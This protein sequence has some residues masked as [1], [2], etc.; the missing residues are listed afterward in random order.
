M[1]GEDSRDLAIG[2]DDDDIATPAVAGATPSNRYI[3]FCEGCNLPATGLR[4]DNTVAYTVVDGD[5]RCVV[6]CTQ[7]HGLESV[8]TW[9]L[10]AGDAEMETV[11]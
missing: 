3:V 9:G 6:D 11:H 10:G 8:E 5:G 7:H 2:D 1:Y 4:T